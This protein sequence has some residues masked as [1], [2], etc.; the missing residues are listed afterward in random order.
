MNMKMTLA[1]WAICAWMTISLTA[2]SQASEQVAKNNAQKTEL[3]TPVPAASNEGEAFVSKQSAQSKLANAQEGSAD[4][5]ATKSGQITSSASNVDKTN[6]HAASSEKSVGD[7]QNGQEIASSTDVQK[8][9]LPQI[10]AAQKKVNLE[11]LPNAL[12]I[13]TVNGIPIT[14]GDY[15]RQFKLQQLQFQ[16]AVATS[17]QARERLLEEANKRGITL[18]TQEKDKLL[19][20]ARGGKSSLSPEFKEFLKQKKA[21]EAQFNQE[22]LDVGLAI[23]T[24]NSMLQ[25]SLLSDMVNRE[26][27]CTAGKA[28]R[29]EDKARTKYLEIKTSPAYKDL[30]AKTSFTPDELRN[31][32]VESEL[33][34]LMMDKIEQRAVVNDKDVE[35]FYKKNPK[36]FAH[37]ERI[38]LSQIIISCP[39]QDVGPVQSVRT[40]VLK[41]NPKLSG[42]ELDATVALTIQ[43]QKEKAE[44]ILAKAKSGADFA[45]LANQNTDDIPTKVGKTGGDLGFQQRS[46]LIP[47]FADAVWPI[48]VGEVYPGLV[49]TA[50]GYHIV[51]VTSREDAGQTPLKEVKEVVR[52]GLKQQKGEQMLASWLQDKRRSTVVGLDPKF[53]ALLSASEPNGKTSSLNAATH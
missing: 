43:H 16:A 53:A 41:A 49:Q 12:T 23:K 33:T 13:C 19:Q 36:L 44:T 30:L 34:K 25:Q 31:E 40:Q 29:L 32:L 14:V 18:D 20:A 27:L 26:I 1:L 39:N 45:E 15:R 52:L 21:T 2:C 46:Q 47:Q 3:S 17:P 7:K 50:L 28:A 6:L 48:K 24:S 51:K 37:K 4:T 8:A 35:D 22:V 9:R 42:K 10:D 11:V 38:R 5:D